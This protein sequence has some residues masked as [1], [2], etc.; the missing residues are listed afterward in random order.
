MQNYL[1]ST[2][3]ILAVSL[4]LTLILYILFVITDIIMSFSNAALLLNIDF[5]VNY[6][7]INIF[8]ELLIHFLITLTIV[9]MTCYVYRNF[10]DLKVVYLCS[11]MIVF[12]LLY[13]ILILLSNRKVFHYE[14]GAHIVWLIAHFIFIVLLN[15]SVKKIIAKI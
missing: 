13:P 6:K 12:I 1:K 2:L 15:F 3:T 11:L 8:E 4:I 14:I 5:L 7:Y 10:Q 9:L